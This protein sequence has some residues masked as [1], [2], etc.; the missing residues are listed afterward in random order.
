MRTNVLQAVLMAAIVVASSLTFTACGENHPTKPS[1]AV[2]EPPIAGPAP[3][4]TPSP[5]PNPTPSGP[6]T[7][8][9]IQ[10]MGNTSPMRV[11]ETRT[12]TAKAFYV[13]P[14]GQESTR[15]VTDLADWTSSSTIAKVEKG[16]VTV[17]SSGGNGGFLIHA[18]FEGVKQSSERIEV[19][20]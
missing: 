10:V 2:P 13:N 12:F 7:V 14:Q 16:V 20:R 3:E 17:T 9:V 18:A 1:A 8:R 6:W 5:N 15:D 19:M 4:P 11:N